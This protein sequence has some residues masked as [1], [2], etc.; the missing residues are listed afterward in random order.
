MINKDS[1]DVAY[2]YLKQC[3]NNQA[4]FNEIWQNVANA[5]EYNPETEQEE[6]EDEY[7]KTV[8]RS[9]P[10]SISL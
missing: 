5:K 6:S 4:S 1:V 10:R 9:N 2:D 3:K 8:C 7:R